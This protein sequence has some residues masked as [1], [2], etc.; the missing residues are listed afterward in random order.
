VQHALLFV[1]NHLAKFHSANFS[2]SGL[3]AG[4]S[5]NLH[6]NLLFITIPNSLFTIHD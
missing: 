1:T 4:A 6:D 2:F 3:K 5:R